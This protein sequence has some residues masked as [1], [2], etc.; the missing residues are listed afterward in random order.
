MTCRMGE[1]ISKQYNKHGINFYTNSSYSSISKNNP[2]KTW[3]EDLN[4]TITEE[5]IQMSKGT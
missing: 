1:N 4:K 2:V 5:D 3:T